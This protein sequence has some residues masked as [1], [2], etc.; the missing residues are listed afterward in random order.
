[1]TP[2]YMP[3][4]KAKRGE[5]TA[6]S[7]LAPEVAEQCW[8]LF[9]IPLPPDPQA[10]KKTSPTPKRDCLDRAIKGIL[11]VRTGL[12]AAIDISAWSPNAQIESGEHVL[13]YAVKELS[14]GGVAVSPVIGFDRW[15]DLDYQAAFATMKLQAGCGFVI[16]FD[17]TSIDDTKDVDFLEDQLASIGETCG[18][19]NVPFGVILDFGDLGAV[20]VVELQSQAADAL[21]RLL[22]W[23]FKFSVV[24]GASLPATINAAV[25]EIDSQDSVLRREIVAWKALRQSTIGAALMFGDYGVRNP[26]SNDGIA[27]HANGK[28]R[29]TTGHN[30]FVARGHSVRLGNG[31]AQFLNLAAVIA[32]SPY[33]RG[34]GFSWGDGQIAACYTGEP[35]QSLEKWIAIDTNHHL[36]AVVEDLRIF[37]VTVADISNK[38]VR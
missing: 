37:A 24:L 1:M 17:K 23:S 9:E 20:P 38:S 30:F 28:I 27:L 2:I 7:N 10:R 4:L 25:G 3:V 11:S 31:Y 21:S 13:S 6:L 18:G 26:R 34:P 33:F 12:G 32:T 5:F 35:I 15:D 19:E 22:P 29:Y 8:P 36:T 14:K 16:R